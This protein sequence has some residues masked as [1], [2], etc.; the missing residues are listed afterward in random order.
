[1]KAFFKRLLARWR[2]ENCSHAIYYD[3][4]MQPRD[5]KG[6]VRCPCYKCGKMLEADCGL[7]LGAQL[8]RRR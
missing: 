2:Q 1:M 7:D 6:I 4:D 3:T 8:Q 5:A